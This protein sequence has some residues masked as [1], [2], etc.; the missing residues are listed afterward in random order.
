MKKIILPGLFCCCVGMLYGQTFSDAIMMK[1][2]EICFALMV[3]QGKWDHYW[4]GNKLIRNENIGTFTRN[5]YAPMIAYGITE[6]LNILLIAPFV[7]TES[8]G[9]QLAGAQGFQD[10]NIGLKYEAIKKDF[11]KHRIS[12]LAVVQFGTPMS[13]YLSDYLPY[14]LGLGTQEFTGRAIGQYEFNKS[15]YFRGSAAYVWRGQTEVERP[16]YYANG[17]YY[18]TYMDVPSAVNY[19]AIVGG[20]ALNHKLR[21]EV[22]YS[23]LNCIS[24]DDIRSWNMPQPTNKMEVTQAGVFA[25][26]YLKAF[27]SLK[28][29]S[30]MAAYSQ[31]LDGR[32]MGKS[33]NI[34]GGI[35]YQFTF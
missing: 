26:Y 6:K 4:E 5:T 13:N 23:T 15:I 19:Q 28:G 18:T 34:S 11:G 33:K 35:T 1:R 32:N 27:E 21:M 7:K 24:G 10:V 8:T 29:F 25:Q 2:K 16:Y 9:G 30:V 20:W 31:V 12:A 17:S 22:T 14:S 3:D